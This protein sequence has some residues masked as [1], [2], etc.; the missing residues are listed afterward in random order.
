MRRRLAV[1]VLILMVLSVLPLSPARAS[2]G[3]SHETYY[4]N[5]GS[6][7]PVG[8][9]GVDC[10]GWHWAEGD[11]TPTQAGERMVVVRVNCDTWEHTEQWYYWMQNDCGD[12]YWTPIPWSSYEPLQPC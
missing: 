3:W 8:S 9:E 6:Q 12:A 1:P 2:V 4:F 10:G 7:G 11:R 5:V